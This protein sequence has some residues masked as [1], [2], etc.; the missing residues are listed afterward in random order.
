MISF[1]NPTSF[2]L[3][4]NSAAQK[5]TNALIEMKHQNT[6]IKMEA[7]VMGDQLKRLYDAIQYIGEGKKQSDKVELLL[8]EAQEKLG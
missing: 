4:L 3:F 2:P 7:E 5:L 8:S 1:E 6:L